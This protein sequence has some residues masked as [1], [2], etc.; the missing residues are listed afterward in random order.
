MKTHKDRNLLPDL[1]IKNIGQLVTV[2][3]ASLTPKTYS[4]MDELGTIKN[5]AVAIKDENIIDVG[6]SNKLEN[7]YKYNN[8]KIIDACEKV[9]MPGFV[10]CHTHAV[11][12]CDR[13]GEFIQ[14]IQGITYLEIL[15]KGGGIL[16]TVKNTRKLKLSELIKTSKM[17]LD[18][19]L[20]HGTTTVEI[21]SGY[22]LNK[23]DELKILKAIQNL[24]IIHH[25]EII[26]TFLGA[27][28]VPLEY[29]KNPEAYVKIVCDMLSEVKPY[30]TFCDIFCDKGGFSP[31]QSE[32]IL[33]SAA[34]LGFKL[35]MHV[36][37]FEDI[38]GISVAIKLG[39]MT[40][41]HL[42]IIKPSNILKMKNSGIVCVL[43][44]GVTFFLMKN[45]YAPAK[46]LIEK[47]LPIAI[48]TDFNPGTCPCNNMQ[49]IITLACL[50]L[51]MTPTQAI[52]AATINAAH[53]VGM[54][55]RI[56]SIETGKQADIIILDIHDYK[57]IPYYFGIN[58][59][60]TVI[61]KGKVVVENK[62]L[63][64]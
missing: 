27:H 63:I 11:F 14:R 45:T 28:T 26:P 64:N 50:N 21:K 43:L 1:I 13:A 5:G 59:V 18:S 54:A 41:D 48:A 33:S 9:V 62:Y 24:K 38:G 6:Q 52:N 19:M 56:G 22:G 47:G 57:H 46:M 35:K 29:K 60:N 34:R 39:A 3:G 31:K 12:G 36:N 49:L 7:K 32:K 10:D 51:G 17:H 40:V 61:K 53:A 44:P 8:I 2:A 55:H 58:H 20:L 42:D 23:K 30:A 16:S 4:E 37:E 15:K 25:I